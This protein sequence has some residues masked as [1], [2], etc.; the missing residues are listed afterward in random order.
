MAVKFAHSVFALSLAVFF[1]MVVTTAQ[2]DHPHHS[3][4]KQVNGALTG[5]VVEGETPAGDTYRITYGKDG[6]ARYSVKDE[7]QNG[8]W[9]VDSG[10]HYCETWE[11]AYGGEKRCAGIEVL[12]PLL[13]FRGKI[14]TTRTI[15]SSQEK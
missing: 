3:T 7:A 12:S 15:V 6:Q 5:A 8:R 13:I 2:A 11:K 14:K 9:S 1:I 10:G 4:A